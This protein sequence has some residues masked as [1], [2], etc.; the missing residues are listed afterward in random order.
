MTKLIKLGLLAYLFVGLIACRDKEP[1]TDVPIPVE[2]AKKFLLES[3]RMVEPDSAE[4]YL[5]KFRENRNNGTLKGVEMPENE[6]MSIDSLMAYLKNAKGLGATNIVFTHGF[7]QKKTLDG[8]G[9]TI[10][11][12][13]YNTYFYFLVP[14]P[15]TG[16][17]KYE[18]LKLDGKGRVYNELTRCP[19]FCDL[20]DHPLDIKSVGDLNPQNEQQG[21]TTN[22]IRRE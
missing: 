13:E 2:E 6:I 14:V 16:T 10:V 21:D 15:S 3:K 1:L 12:P 22:N 5:T 17:N 9:N 8:G 19:R 7:T 20:F 11:V 4:K 18:M